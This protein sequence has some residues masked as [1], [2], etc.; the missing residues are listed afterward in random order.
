[1]YEQFIDPT[2]EFGG[3]CCDFLQ[4]LVT[5]LAPVN[6]LDESKD[7]SPSIHLTH[8]HIV[9]PTFIK[10]T[11]IDSPYL[12]PLLNYLPIFDRIHVCASA[13]EC[14]RIEPSLLGE[15]RQEECAC[16]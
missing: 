11:D 15:K 9:E 3:P 6:R 8:P 2:I 7:P 4:R 13:I 1:M 14:V 16:K 12:G 5:G 10:N